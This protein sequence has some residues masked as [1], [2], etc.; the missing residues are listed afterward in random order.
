VKQAIL[1]F[2]PDLQVE[3]ITKESSGDQ[4]KDIP[5]QT[6]E[7]T[8]FFTGDFFEDLHNGVADIAVHSLKDMSGEHFFAGNEFAIVD[9]DDV[10]DVA[11]FNPDVEQN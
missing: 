9:R 11:I 1:Q 4:L 5:L 6:V 8:D 3:V 7:G 10:R 2:Y